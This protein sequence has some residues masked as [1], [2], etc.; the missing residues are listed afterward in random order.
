V[1]IEVP[2][3]NCGDQWVSLNGE[4][5]FQGL[6][7]VHVVVNVDGVDSA[8]K[9]GSVRFFHLFWCNWD[10]TWFTKS[11]Q[12]VVTGLDWAEPVIHGSVQSHN[13]F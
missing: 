1:G 13:Q 11:G 8:S 9:S 10:H 12:V 4:Y 6:S 7:I 3:D 5:V 2:T